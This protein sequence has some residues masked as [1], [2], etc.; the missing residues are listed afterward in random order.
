MYELIKFIHIST[1]I[2]F[3][4][5]VYFRTFVILKIV[6]SFPKDQAIK[7]QQAMGN[8]A[9][10]IIKINNLILIISGMLLL[11]LYTNNSS[12]ILHLKV[13]LGLILVVG[14]YFVPILFNKFEADQK[15]KTIFHYL[16]FSLLMFVVLLSQFIYSF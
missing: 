15:F 14:F 1:I 9:R 7:I 3:V 13:L 8:K 16:F 2:L 11:F 12:L 5:T 4:G 10:N 6:S